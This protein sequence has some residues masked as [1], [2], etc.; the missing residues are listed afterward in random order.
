MAND[1]KRQSRMRKKMKKY[2]PTGLRLTVFRSL[3]NIYA[4]VIDDAKNQT[5]VSA[6]SVE[7]AIDKKK[8]MELSVEVGKLVAKRALEKGIKEVYFDR[9][10]YKYHGRIKAVADSA[11][12]EGLKF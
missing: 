4:Q 12:K 7:K 9:G 5:L 8:K 11:R 2:N 1:I 6:S 3:K 10:R